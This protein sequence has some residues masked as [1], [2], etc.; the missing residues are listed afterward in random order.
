MIAGIT[1]G[2]NTTDGSRCSARARINALVAV[3]GLVCSTVG[4]IDTLSATARH[5]GIAK[6][7]SA[8][9]AD[10]SVV[11]AAIG[12]WFTVGVNSARVRVTQITFVEWATT[13]ERMTSV[14]FRTR[15]NSLVIL[16]ATLG[17]N[18][19][20]VSARIDALEIET[21]LRLGALFVLCTLGVAAGERI[22]K[23][24]GRTRADCTMVADVT[25]GVGSA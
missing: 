2:S 4:V 22:S 11:S 13:V 19:T 14:S 18:T 9:E 6:I 17:S 1:A 8:T 10:G 3:T 20:S 21:S 16:Y 15:A 7:S 12:S 5:K 23:K 25:I 24:I